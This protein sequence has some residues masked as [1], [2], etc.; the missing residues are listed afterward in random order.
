MTDTPVMS[1]RLPFFNRAAGVWLVV[2]VILV[3]G[4]TAQG[5]LLIISPPLGRALGLEDLHI[6]GFLGGG[7]LLAV[8]LAP[9]WGRMSERHGRL[10]V[11]VLAQGLAVL[12]WSLIALA[13]WLRFSARIGP[14]LT[15]LILVAGRAVQAAG[16]SGILPATVALIADRT[17]EAA[18]T[19][20][21]SLVGAAYGAGGILGGALMWMI[22][23]SSAAWVFA[24][25]AV[26]II[27]TLLLPGMLAP[28]AT[29]PARATG[30]LPW[31][32]VLRPG[33][34]ALLCSTLT[35]I[36]AFGIVKQV[37]G[38]WLHDHLNYPLDLAVSRGGLAMTMT[39]AAI[40]LVQLVVVP[41]LR[42]R[43]EIL[44]AAGAFLAVISLISCS[45]APGFAVLLFGLSGLGIAGGLM[46]PGN[47]ASLSLRTGESGQ[48]EI[49]GL[50]VMAQSAGLVLGPVLGGVLHG[51]SP[52]WPYPAAAA[53]MGVSL[54]LSWRIWKTRNG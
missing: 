24:G 28:G 32:R 44:Q 13:I 3:I 49:A 36:T 12:G 31:R 48:G 9:L 26:L 8:A 52:D 33:S 39:A 1:A 4:A 14:Q 22:A 18:R 46:L 17:P 42:C 45:A 27:M 19:R 20:A 51:L 50:N 16:T 11:L 25:F 41:F 23:L 40:I 37:T 2:F 34:A 5:Y 7:A 35:A 29:R 15:L 38:L 53:L 6:V 21:M 43:P 10:R 30:A 54:A 47:L